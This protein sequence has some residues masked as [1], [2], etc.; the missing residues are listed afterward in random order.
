MGNRCALRRGSDLLRPC[1]R[2]HLHVLGA[3]G[4]G[5]STLL[6]NLALS[7]IEAGRGVVVIDPKGDLVSDILDRFPASAT[8]PVLIDPDEAACSP[9]LNV[10]DAEK[11]EHDLV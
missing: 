10:L 8:A 3:T 6:T 1:D 7:D 2:S 4:S 9:V 11:G 5:K